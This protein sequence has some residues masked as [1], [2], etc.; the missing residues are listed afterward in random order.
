MAVSKTKVVEAEDKLPEQEIPVAA[1]LADSGKEVKL[2]N[3]GMEL[4]LE[5]DFNMERELVALSPEAAE[6]VVKVFMPHIL[7]HLEGVFESK[8]VEEV[9]GGDEGE[10]EVEENKADE[11][12]TAVADLIHD[13]KD[14]EKDK[15]K[16][17]LE[18]LRKENKS[19]KEE[20]SRYALSTPTFVV[21]ATESAVAPTPRQ[22]Y[23]EVA[24]KIWG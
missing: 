22:T 16:A 23:A 14:D 21:G 5:D 17:E 19:L 10:P 11:V 15:Y 24:K 1:E 7:K 20:R 4:D 8:K 13:V 3:D 12:E 9:E 2:E 18:S 6:N